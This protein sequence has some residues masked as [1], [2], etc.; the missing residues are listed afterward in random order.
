MISSSL[1]QKGKK[2]E[3]QKRKN[4]EGVSRPIPLQKM[5]DIG[6]GYYFDFNIKV[7]TGFLSIF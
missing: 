2:L 7:S 6:S 1:K 3:T 5:S 4:K